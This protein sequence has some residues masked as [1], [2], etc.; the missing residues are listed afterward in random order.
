MIDRP[1]PLKRIRETF[2]VHPVASLLGP[3]QCGKTTLARIV[4]A[5]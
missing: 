3:R 1:E 2:R 4:A 5:I